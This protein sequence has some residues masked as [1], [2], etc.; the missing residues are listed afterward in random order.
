[1]E[2]PPD[3]HEAISQTVSAPADSSYSELFN[4]EGNEQEEAED[5]VRQPSIAIAK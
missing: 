5:R 4:R 1:M 3:L 2:E